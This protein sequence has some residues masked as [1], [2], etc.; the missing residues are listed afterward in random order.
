MA[1]KTCSRKASPRGGFFVITVNI[2]VK[3][4]MPSVSSRNQTHLLAFFGGDSV[5]MLPVVFIDYAA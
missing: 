3:K 1:P 4:L 5:V 2:G